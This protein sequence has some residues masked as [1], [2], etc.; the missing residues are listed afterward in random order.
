MPHE[1]RAGP[2]RANTKPW[3]CRLLA[4]LTSAIAPMLFNEL[5]FDQVAAWAMPSVKA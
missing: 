2:R 4:G 5:V 3:R 1:P